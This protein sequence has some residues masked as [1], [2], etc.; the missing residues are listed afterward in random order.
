MFSEGG[1]SKYRRPWRPP[2]ELKTIIEPHFIFQFLSCTLALNSKEA[3]M[4]TRP[5]LLAN[6]PCIF[7]PFYVWAKCSWLL[8][9][10]LAEEIDSLTP[11]FHDFRSDHSGS[12][13][14]IC[15]PVFKPF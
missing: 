5:D 4:R 7:P 10:W 6:N 15:R 13:R 1:K 12:E 3:F 14:K 2:K 9:P 8:T 11:E